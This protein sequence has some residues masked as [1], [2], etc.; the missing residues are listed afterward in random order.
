MAMNNHSTKLLRAEN[1]QML[2]IDLQ[3]KF[4]PVIPGI[5]DILLN[6][7]F[8][9]QVA[10]L[11]N[12]PI[13]VTEQ[14]P[15]GLGGTVAPI[16]DLVPD[17]KPIAKMT[18]SCWRDETIRQTLIRQD[19]STVLL[20]GIETPICLLQT[21][22]DLLNAG[23][24]V[25]MLTDAIGARKERDQQFAYRRLE[26]AG[27]IL[28]TAETAAFELIERADAPVFKSLLKLIKEYQAKK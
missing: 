18:F 21:G 27:A 19:R 16:C 4:A 14:N 3:E 2:I 17:F 22:L 24:D 15:A 13:T 5:D 23:Y 8:A 7:A 28:G 20:A 10:N 26:A 9:V 25:Y 11:M 1:C 12:I 6:T